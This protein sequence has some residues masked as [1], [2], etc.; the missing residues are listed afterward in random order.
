MTTETPKPKAPKVRITEPAPVDEPTPA[1]V[2]TV[3]EAV[4]GLFAALELVP[5]DVI[6]LAINARRGRIRVIGAD[7]TVRSPSF[8][9]IEAAAE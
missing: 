7:R 9:P 2:P 5:Q 4:A 8:T 1:A 3:D 6:E